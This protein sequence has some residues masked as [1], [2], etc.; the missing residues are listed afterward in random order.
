MRLITSLCIRWD[1][2][3]F[4]SDTRTDIAD[5]RVRFADYLHMLPQ[6]FPKLTQLH[7]ILGERTYEG[8]VRAEANREQLEVVLLQPLLDARIRMGDQL[9]DFTVAAPA[10]L[11]LAFLSFAALSS[12][13]E[14]NP[15]LKMR[16]NNIWILRIWYPFVEY[17]TPQRRFNIS[18]GLS[19][20]FV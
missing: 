13:P 20:P 15:T 4:S 11:F 10:G 1:L 8:R 12:Q 2:I 3:L 18:H 7:L 16:T 17:G 9:Q 19:D 5:H 6:A 14:D